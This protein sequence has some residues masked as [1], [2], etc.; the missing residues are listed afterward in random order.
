[1]VLGA[2]PSGSAAATALTRRAL[3]VLIVEEQKTRTFKVGESL[4]GFA[5]K[6]IVG[7]GFPNVLPRVS[8]IRCS[9]NRSCW[10]SSE[11]RLRPGLLDPYGGGIHV[12]RAE[13]DEELVRASV[14]AGAQVLTGARFIRST[15]SQAGWSVF[16]QYNGQFRTVKCDSVVDCTGRRACFARTQSKHRIIIDKQVAA[17]SVLSGKGV[18]D[19]DLTTTIE[20][21]PE[22]WW[23]STR[24]PNSRRIV[25]FFTD[26]DLLRKL[27]ARSSEVFF[28]LMR[29]TI[30]V[31]KFLSA[32]YDV[33][34]PPAVVLAD[35]S[36][37]TTAAGRGWCAAGD[38]AAALD[39]LGSAG[40]IDA[41]K[42]GSAA[43][44]L[45]LSGF[46]DSEDYSLRVRDR[47]ETN[48]KTR[49]AYYLMEGRWPR[50]PFWARRHEV[51]SE[52]D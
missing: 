21:V 6:V 38:A 8:Q 52:T 31:R 4:P 32:G 37:L 42:S 49:R 26:G 35:T 9:G 17:V 30:Y 36:Y 2:G 46:K 20:A 33:E 16:L 39:P 13:L 19:A 43:A 41:L 12:D 7:A 14:T 11:M 29:R 47:A 40:V 15:R 22:G 18:S 45:V 28:S 34:R 5:R 48:I 25:V 1:M 24:I 3:T 44:R 23:Y 10:G 27:H 50:A 51:M